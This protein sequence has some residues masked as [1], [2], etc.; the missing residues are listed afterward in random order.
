MP[1]L[2]WYHAAMLHFTLALSRCVM[3]PGPPSAFLL[4]STVDTLRMHVSYHLLTRTHYYLV[5]TTATASFSLSEAKMPLSV[6]H[7]PFASP[8]HGAEFPYFSFSTESENS[9]CSTAFCPPPTLMPRTCNLLD[10]ASSQKH[11][12]RKC[13]PSMR[14]ALRKSILGVLNAECSTAEAEV[15]LAVLAAASGLLSFLTIEP[16]AA[17]IICDKRAT[18]R[19]K[20]RGKENQ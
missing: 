12:S 9:H 8:S 7:V 5:A 2:C 20:R 10:A 19:G 1:C 15:G 3:V 4:S 17:I 6:N 18:K 13:V 11:W 16:P 14:R